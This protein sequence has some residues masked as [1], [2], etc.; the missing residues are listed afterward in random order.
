MDLGLD[1]DSAN[2]KP[3][4]PSVGNNMKI[5]INL[6]CIIFFIGSNLHFFVS[7]SYTVYFLMS[8]GEYFF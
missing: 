5:N 4:P 7:N 6:V 1:E 2:R 3:S 8:S